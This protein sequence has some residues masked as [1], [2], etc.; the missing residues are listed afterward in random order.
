MGIAASNKNAIRD[1]AHS[2]S[3][4]IGRILPGGFLARTGDQR[5]YTYPYLMMNYNF[6]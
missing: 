1:C 2:H 5:N 6:Y 3:D 4:G